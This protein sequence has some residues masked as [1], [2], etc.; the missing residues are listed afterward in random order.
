MIS[1][2]GDKS[3]FGIPLR[4]KTQRTVSDKMKEKKGQYVM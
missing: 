2:S 4:T 1:E 3:G